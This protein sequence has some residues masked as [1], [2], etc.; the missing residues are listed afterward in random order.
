MDINYQTVFRLA[1]EIGYRNFGYYNAG[2]NRLNK[3]DGLLEGEIDDVVICEAMLIHK[4]LRTEYDS[5]VTPIY[6]GSAGYKMVG[7]LGP[8]RIQSVNNMGFTKALLLG[9]H[10]TL[11]DIKK[12]IEKAR[13]DIVD[14]SFIKPTVKPLRKDNNKLSV[15][16][17]Y[18]RPDD[19]PDDVVVRRWLAGGGMVDLASEL[20]NLYNDVQAARNSLVQLGLVNIGRTPEDAECI[21]E[22]WI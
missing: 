6:A 12:R 10:S 17:I 14:E 7:G 1:H 16:T 19:Y 13:G 3:M 18:N 15:F 11:D 8:H 9:I 4:W 22:S 5:D 2:E 21:V 20:P